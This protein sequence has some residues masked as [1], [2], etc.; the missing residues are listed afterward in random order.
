MK[1]TSSR[2]IT[3]LMSVYNGERW[4]EE[5]IISVLNQTFTDFEFIIVDD[6]STDQTAEI[7]EQ[8]TQRDSR[9]R[10]LTKGNSGLADSLNYGISHSRGE[11]I[12]RIDADDICEPS[13]L[14]KQVAITQSDSSIVLVGSGLV[15]IDEFGKKHRQHS[16]PAGHYRLVQRLA[17]HGAFPPHSSALFKKAALRRQ[18]AYRTRIR[19]SQDRDLWLRLSEKG[20]IACV[21]KP[22]VRIRKH[23][24]QVSHE[25]SGKRQL[26]D[27][28]VAMVSYWLRR[29]GVQDPVDFYSDS[30][31][32]AFRAW[33][34]SS[35]NADSFLR[36][37]H[38]TAEIKT[39]VSNSAGIIKGVRT[40][41]R[42]ITYS[43]DVFY[44]WASRKVFGSSLPKRLAKKWQRLA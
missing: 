13:R 20:K 28:H 26:V 30:D 4:L 2:P 18:T 44:Y 32:T 21:N 1:S 41:L 37:A 10:V 8:F 3:V 35:L 27:S 15:I 38:F 33:V 31:F 7:L 23:S 14:E 9:V 43:P 25:E 24:A 34:S 42:S 39:Q 40:L 6:G 22:L 5:S 16:Y 19:R 29:C 36:L 12:A 11:W 17:R